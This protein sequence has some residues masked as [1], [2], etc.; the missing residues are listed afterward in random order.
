MSA[1]N[2]F[3]NFAPTNDLLIYQIVFNNV[4]T[5]IIME[6]KEKTS[7]E[8]LAEYEGGKMWIAMLDVCLLVN[9]SEIAR[10]YFKKSVNWFNQRLHGYKVN[11]KPAEFKPDELKTLSDALRDIANKLVQAA[12]EVDNVRMQK[13]K[14]MTEA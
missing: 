2:N 14:Q 9:F 10:T 7:R 4:K 5:I 6:K 11:G 8:L 3:I 1:N 12:V 13:E